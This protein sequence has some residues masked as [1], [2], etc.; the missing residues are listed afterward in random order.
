MAELEYGNRDNLFNAQKTKS[1]SGAI[2]DL[3]YRLVEREPLF[4]DVPTFPANNGATHYGYRWITDIEP[5]ISAIGGGW[6]S[7]VAQGQ[8]Y[9]E[10]MFIARSRYQ[11]PVDVLQ[12]LGSAAGPNRDAQEAIHEKSMQRGWTST[13]IRGSADT[14]G[15]RIDGIFN[16]APWNVLTANYCESMGGNSNLRSMILINPG[17]SKFHFIYNK[18]N[19]T[20]GVKREPKP[21]VFVDVTDTDA[22]GSGKRWDTITEF[23]FE[24]GIVIAE[25]MAIKRICNIDYTAAPT[26]ALINK[27]RRLRLIHDNFIDGQWFLYC[28]PEMFINLTNLANSEQNVQYS[29]DNPYRMSLPM[30]G[31]IIVRNMQALYYDDTEVTA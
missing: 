24:H 11:C 29:S 30:I 22:N 12:H 3:T 26:E 15:K 20:L 23:E 6:T 19:P 17:I 21:D 7:S 13:V 8:N 31:D 18:D 25:N 5:T 28:D 10:A 1:P 9:S 16:R 27:I 4:R 2:L 14:S